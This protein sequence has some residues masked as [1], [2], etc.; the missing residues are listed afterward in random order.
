MKKWFE[1]GG[2]KLKGVRMKE[3]FLKW[4]A[5]EPEVKKSLIGAQ[6]IVNF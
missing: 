6:A 1:K 2:R 3:A 4:G 5:H